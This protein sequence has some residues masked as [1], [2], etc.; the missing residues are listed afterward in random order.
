MIPKIQK[1]SHYTSDVEK[2]SLWIAEY[3]S[4]DLLLGGLYKWCLFFIHRRIRYYV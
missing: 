1:K 2:C 4:D 3:G